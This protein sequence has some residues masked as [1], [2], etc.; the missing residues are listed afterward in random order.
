MENFENLKKEIEEIE[1]QIKETK[2]ILENP[3]NQDLFTLAKEEL[4]TLSKKVEIF[5]KKIKD[6]SDKELRKQAVIIEIRAGVGGEESALFAV[7]LFRMYS[8]F[9]QFQGWKQRILDSRRTELGGYKEIVFEIS[10]AS[11]GENDNIWSQLKYEA[12]V[13]RV[14]RIPQTEKAERVHTSTVSVAVLLKPKKTT[15]KIKPDD[16]RVDCYRASGPGGQYVNKRDTAIRITHIPTGIMVTSQTERSQLQNKENAMAILE[17][18]IL[19]KKQ[20]EE[21]EKIGNERKSQIHAAKRAE[22]IRTYNFPQDRMTDH[23]VK[24]TWH[25]LEKILNGNLEPVIKV[26]AKKL[27]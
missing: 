3:E 6:S 14:Q 23:R 22:K 12:G 7:E 8:R 9:A 10:P 17:A 26:L 13:H 2:Q 4:E 24:K 18:K 20:A 25:N 19:K 21:K 16:L 15:V 1:N 5:E 11:R 27:T